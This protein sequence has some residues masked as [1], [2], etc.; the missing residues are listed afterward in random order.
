ME[1]KEYLLQRYHHS[2]AM[3]YIRDINNY[4]AN[5]EKAPS[6]LYKDV[7]A[8]IGTL[9]TRYPNN[10]TLK[11]ITASI[12]AY[13]DYL[14]YT[15]QRKDNPAKAI[16][17]RDKINKDIQLQDLFTTAELEILLEK[18]ERYHVMHYRNRVL[19]SL[20]IYQALPPSSLV[21]IEVN[22]INLQQGTIYIKA[23]HNINSR[24]LQLKPSQVM[25][26]HQYINEA[27]NKLIQHKKNKSS[28]LLLR[29][30]GNPM[31][32]EEVTRHVIK[33]YNNKYPGRKVNPQTIRQSVLSNLLKEGKDTRIV[34][35]FAGHKYLSTTEKYKQSNADT[36]KSLIQQYHP[37]K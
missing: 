9:R 6:A 29:K 25:L 27:R 23:M 21:R 30:S 34:Q 26:L 15:G 17:L 20:L 35:V 32:G 11:K 12:K 33:N 37:I 28:L 19:M 36:L 3:S 13:Y 18:K 14:N 4:T 22:D 8:Y 5:Y 16:R 10:K 24:E 31:L 2:T 7:V 1:L